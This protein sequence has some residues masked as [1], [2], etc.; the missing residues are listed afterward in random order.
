MSL[1]TKPDGLRPSNL[2]IFFLIKYTMINGLYFPTNLSA[3]LISRGDN[4]FDHPVYS[5]LLCYSHCRRLYG[6]HYVPFIN[7]RKPVYVTRRQ[8]DRLMTFIFQL[9]PIIAVCLLMAVVAG[10][11]AWAIES[12]HNADFPKPFIPGLFQ[13]GLTSTVFPA[14]RFMHL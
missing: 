12:K 4:S 9:G 2:A 8:K 7:A 6:F 5:I 11:I 14:F 1:K 10:F 13:G 3:S